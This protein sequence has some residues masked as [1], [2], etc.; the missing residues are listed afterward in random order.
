[1]SATGIN[2]INAGF[3]IVFGNVICLS[4]VDA[5]ELSVFNSLVS[6][7]KTQIEMHDQNIK[8]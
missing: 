1:M 2:Q 5:S 6:G 4:D 3:S 8:V 7:T